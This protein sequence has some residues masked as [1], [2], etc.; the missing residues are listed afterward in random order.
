LLSSALFLLTLAGCA[1][2]SNVKPSLPLRHSL[3][4]YSNGLR[5]VVYETPRATH[6]TVIMSYA[7]GG[8][9]DP[10]GKEGLAALAVRLTN[11]SRPGGAQ[12]PTLKQQGLDLKA[13]TESLT[14]PELVVFRTT[15]PAKNLAQ[16]LA[17]EAQRLREPLA[18]VTEAEFVR[19]G[20]GASARRCAYSPI[21]LTMTRLRRWPS[22]SA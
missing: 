10:A 15:L 2:T 3:A 7:V 20:P 21:T 9:D 17:V 12:A 19:V 14:S 8:R 16:F 1:H 6:A 11:A 5:L 13:V 18:N 4:T 22:N